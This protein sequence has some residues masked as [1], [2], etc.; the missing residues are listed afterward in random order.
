M[1][2]VCWW[3]DK[4]SLCVCWLSGLD[5]WAFKVWLRHSGAQF[6]LAL[7]SAAL[8]R[9]AVIVSPYHLDR[10]T[11]VQH[12][13]LPTSH[14]PVLNVKS[15]IGF[16]LHASNGATFFGIVCFLYSLPDIKYSSSCSFLQELDMHKWSI[17]RP[18]YSIYASD[19][20]F[21]KERII[22]YCIVIEF[23]DMLMLVAIIKLQKYHCSTIH[24]NNRVKL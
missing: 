7:H 13:T 18:L 24:V 16:W 14:C 9:S 21:F 15:S 11:A 3:T 8:H 1:Q 19:F 23:I 4:G 22:L 5:L 17:Q 12:T 20:F 2:L 6:G 10:E